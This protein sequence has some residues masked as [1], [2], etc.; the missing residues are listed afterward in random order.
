MTSVS[1][2][3]ALERLTET[4]RHYL[5]EANLFSR[6]PVLDCQDQQ[7][8]V[9]LLVKH[10]APPVEDPA[11]LLRELKA[12]FYEVMPEVGLP[13]EWVALQEMPVRL[14]LQIEAEDIPYAT[15]TFTWRI[16]DAL[17][18]IFELPDLEEPITA[19]E[20]SEQLPQPVPD[21][22]EAAEIAREEERPE[23][24]EPSAADRADDKAT[25]EEHSLGALVTLND[26]AL[27][28]PETAVDP[29]AVSPLQRWGQWGVGQIQQL[30]SYWSYGLAGLILLSSGLFA[31][32]VTR[33]CVVDGCDRIDKAAAF[34]IA[35]Q[36]RIGNPPATEDLQVARSELQA[37]VDLV[38]PIPHWSRYYGE[39]RSDLSLYRADLASL[40]HLS[41]AQKKAYTAAQKSQDPPHPVEHWVDIQHLWRQAIAALEAIAA[42]SPLHDFAQTKLGEYEANLTVIAQ[43][44]T[45]E[46][47][48]EANLNS[49]LQSGRL[50]QQQMDAA[51]SL[52]GW[53]RADQEWQR[54][55]QGLTLIPQGTEA[56]PAAQARLQE[57]RTQRAQVQARLNQ[58]G[59][60]NDIYQQ[61]Q[62]AANQA[63]AYEA[64]N[65]WTRAV[66][67]WK[68]ALATIQQ[69]SSDSALVQQAKVLVPTYQAAL[70][71]SQAQLRTAVALQNLEAR[72]GNVCRSSTTSC[73]ISATPDQIK[74]TLAGQ[75]A[76]ALERAI[77]PPANAAP[78]NTTLSRDAQAMVEQIVLLGNQVQRQIEIYDAQGRFVARYR[79]DLGGFVK[80]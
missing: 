4:F 6:L 74:V 56:Y 48:A 49:A 67:Q 1:P 53:R 12:V 35:A 27:A 58:E 73:R 23:A 29:P 37:A 11:G 9:L 17:G 21:D 36:T 68:I 10:P 63:K 59:N 28:L 39:S 24:T 2:R 38:A 52:S 7:G 62:A 25:V 20:M 61:A 75:Y 26:A 30:A 64:Q 18:L 65:Q 55:I 50:A 31:Y 46:E 69:V 71:R 76:V 40:D 19:V 8:R 42:T 47:A 66:N 5:Q 22:P 51:T 70:A 41:E 33:P 57:Y 34:H 54:A 45:A 79:P 44:I 78:V 16:E 43:R 14:G 80:N 77:T 32:T 13:K 60:A 3:P 15:H 72:L